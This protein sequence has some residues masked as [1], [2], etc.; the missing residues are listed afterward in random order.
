M[1]LHL[2]SPEKGCIIDLKQHIKPVWLK[3]AQWLDENVTIFQTDRR[4]ITR[5]QK[6]LLSAQVSQIHVQRINRGKR[7]E[8]KIK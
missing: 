4:R 6:S 1:N 5:D 8:N 7:G 2:N 3:L